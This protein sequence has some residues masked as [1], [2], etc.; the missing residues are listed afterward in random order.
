[1]HPAPPAPHPLARTILSTPPP[2]MSSAP[3]PATPTRPV[4]PGPSPAGTHGTHGTHGT[5]GTNRPPSRT[6]PAPFIFFIICLNTARTHPYNTVDRSSASGELSLRAP[7]VPV[8]L[9]QVNSP[10]HDQGGP[11][12]S[13]GSPPPS[14]HACI[15]AERTHH[16][17]PAGAASA[18]TSA[19]WAKRTQAGG[20][21]A[22]W[23][24]IPVPCTAVCA[25]RT[26]RLPRQPA[27]YPC[28]ARNSAIVIVFTPSP[29]ALLSFDPASSP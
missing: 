11:L 2:C 19:K 25:E 12:P 29:S 18:E 17:H 6:E 26:H 22:R 16:P 4:A 15:C 21:W 13:P 8:P 14:R 3:I 5:R 24:I 20:N 23:A 9:S 1:M 27:E 10:R 28:C 7:G